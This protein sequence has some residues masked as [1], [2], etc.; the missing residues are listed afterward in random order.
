M[1]P[2]DAAVSGPLKYMAGWWIQIGWAGVDLF[3]VLSGF[4]VSGLLFTE[5]Q[6]R[7]SLDI[8]RF[9]IRRGLKIYPGFYFM[10][11]ATVVATVMTGLFKAAMI[12]RIA[13]EILYLQNYVRGLWNHTWSLAIEEHFYVLLAV[14]L[15]VLVRRPPSEWNDDPFR[16]FLPLAIFIVFAIAAGRLLT[17]YAAPL[18]GRY[19]DATVLPL[20]THLRIDT[21]GVGVIASYLYHYHRQ[22]FLNTAQRHRTAIKI[23][24]ALLL[25]PPLFWPRVSRRGCRPWDCSASQ[26]ALPGWSSSA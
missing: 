8:V 23:A 18:T 13:A 24:S 21:L 3:F 19:V 14:G 5:Y 26:S 12:P 7:G 1:A 15:F 25:T 2:P 4:L 6:E 16:R 17:P 22:W 10:I 11:G 9:L 20:G